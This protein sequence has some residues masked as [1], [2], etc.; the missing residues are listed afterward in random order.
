MAPVTFPMTRDLPEA[1]SRWHSH[2]Y[3]HSNA[4][5]LQIKTVA[6]VA[7]TGWITQLCGNKH[8][9]YYIIINTKQNSLKHRI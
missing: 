1:V 3:S 7:Q 9:S 6:S 4:N 8:D 2:S 5:F